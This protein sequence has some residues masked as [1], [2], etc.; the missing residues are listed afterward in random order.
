MSLSALSGTVSQPLCGEPGQQLLDYLREKSKLLVMDNFEHLLAGPEPTRG[1]GT[2]LI[3]DVLQTAP[4]VKIL[5][6]SRARLNV[7]GEHLFRLAGMDLPDN[8]E[9]K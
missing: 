5:T 9:I 3:S 6:T 2:A 4:E 8:V 1:N 7:Q